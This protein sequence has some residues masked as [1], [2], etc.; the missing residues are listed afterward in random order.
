MTLI[1][2]SVL[3]REDERLLAGKGSFLADQA[4]GAYHVVFVRSDI[5]HGD[6]RHIDVSTAQEAPGVVGVF[7]ADQLGLRDNHI[8]LLHEPDPEFVAATAFTMAD[9]RLALMAERRVHYAGQIVAAVVA[10]DR[11]LAE[12]AAELVNVGYTA[13]PVVVEMEDA[14]DA[15]AP[16]LHDHLSSNEAASLSFAFGDPDSARAQAAVTVAETYRIGRHG[17]V[18][19]ECRGV[20]TRIDHRTGEVDVWSSTQVPHMVRRGIC[21]ATGWTTDGVRVHVPDVGG[22]FGTKAN[23]YPEEI[24]VPLLARLTGRDVVWVEDRQEHLTA[25]AQGR[26]QV[27]RCV[28]SVD[29]DGRILSL[30]DDFLVNIG[31]GSLWVAGIIANTAI[32]ILGPYRVPAARVGGKGIFTNKAVVAQYR[33]AGRPEASFVLERSLDAAARRLGLTNVEIRRRNLLTAQDMPYPRPLPYR[34]GVPIVY[35]GGDYRACLDAALDLLPPDVVAQEQA[36]HPELRI[37][38]GV[39]CYLEATGRGPYEAAQI[40]V[41]PQGRIEV[42]TGAASAGQGHET[43]FAQV[44]A[45]SLGLPM[46]AV[47]LLPT[48]TGSLA[49]GIGTFASR[50][51]VLAGNAIAQTAALLVDAGRR[52]YA[53]ATGADLADVGYREGVFQAP[54]RDPAGWRELARLGAPGEALEGEPPLY[55]ASMY[56][57]RTVTWTMGAHATVVGVHPGTGIVRVLRYAVA[58]EGG[59]EINPL[60][61]EGQVLGGVA[62]G[63]GGTL[64]EEFRYGADGGPRS[65][66][67]AEYGLPGASEVPEVQIRHLGV[68]TDNPLGVRG[69]GESGTIAVA[70]AVAAAID[71]ATGC[72]HVTA[73][74]IAPRT[75]KSALDAA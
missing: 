59:V 19:L 54:G 4:Q 25:A 58:H 16:V 57:C 5:A 39:G 46:E 31:A 44:A 18:P 6:L 37:G 41:T 29:A 36:A 8:A 55:A 60:V 50:S 28:L 72:T 45:E 47:R 10:S 63:I 9:Q 3:R 51:A 40:T 32:H 23:V 49:H 15:G 65:T 1:G 66:T 11:Y 52:R 21:A 67:F 13:L 33:G 70:A 38:H 14:L 69:A 26:D 68:P 75:I 71:A 12:D 2:T 43:S 48:D 42:M 22:G 53:R 30:E 56:R 17:A 64:F 7:T 35:D 24:L 62:Q 73:T 34:D 20:L 74:P 27:H 61:V